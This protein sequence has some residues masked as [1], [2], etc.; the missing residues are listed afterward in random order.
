MATSRRLAWTGR[1]CPPGTKSPL[2]RHVA[3]SEIGWISISSPPIGSAPA[4][5]SGSPGAKSP[6]GTYRSPSCQC[7]QSQISE[8]VSRTWS[9]TDGQ[10]KSGALPLS[11]SVWI[12]PGLSA[13]FRDDS[14]W[15]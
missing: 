10:A 7:P 8:P 13:A 5:P 3:S 2:T 11:H 6:P 12:W 4:V 9:P 15:S 1:R 14:S